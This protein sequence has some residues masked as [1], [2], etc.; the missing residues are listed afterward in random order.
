MNPIL[1]AFLALGLGAALCIA[2]VYL[3]AGLGWALIAG[4][5]PLLVLAAI[6]LRGLQ[7][8]QQKPT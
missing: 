4:S 5:V 1:I 6:I 2:G 7:R 8:A 3:L